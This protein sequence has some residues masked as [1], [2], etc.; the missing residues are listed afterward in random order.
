[1]NETKQISTNEHN[2]EIFREDEKVKRK[3]INGATEDKTQSLYMYS[4]QFHSSKSEL[5]DEVERYNDE[6]FEIYDTEEI[7]EYDDVDNVF[8]DSGSYDRDSY[9]LDEYNRS[10]NDFEFDRDK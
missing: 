7:K 6:E 9:N 10:K 5:K 3:K 4:S 2:E 1:M 8:E